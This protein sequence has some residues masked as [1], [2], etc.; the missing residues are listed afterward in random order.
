MT[1]GAMPSVWVLRG[2]LAAAVVLALLAGIPEGYRPPVVLVALVVAGSLLAAF[3]PEHLALS[4]TM[5]L[6]LV[7]WALQLRSEMPVAVLVA[8]ASLTAAHV[9]ATLLA[10]GP[11]TLPIDLPLA[12]LWFTRGAMAWTAALAVWV[13]ARAY[14]GHGSPGLFWL[15]GLAAALVAAV[16]AGV[17]APLRGEERRG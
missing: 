4:I 10:Y 2:I 15:I 3:R 16:V 8:A 6:V 17:A 7:W 12:V 13:V 9:A 14:T 11:P 1:R 5:T